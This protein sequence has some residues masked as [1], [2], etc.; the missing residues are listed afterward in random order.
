MHLK[1]V[2]KVQ[3][4]PQRRMPWRAT[5]TAVR[6]VTVV[7]RERDDGWQGRRGMV[8]GTSTQCQHTLVSNQIHTYSV[9]MYI[10]TY[11][12][13]FSVAM[14]IQTYIHTVHSNVCTYVH[15]YIQW[16]NVHTYIHAYSVAMYIQY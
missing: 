8:N 11:V 1:Y 5:S 13:T 4:T 9:A 3:T 14:Y 7:T 10:H 16:S 12:R 6:P 15:M 2:S